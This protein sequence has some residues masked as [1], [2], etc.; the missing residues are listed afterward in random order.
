MARSGEI[1]V[2]TRRPEAPRD[3]DFAL[4]IDFK[5]G[6]PNPYRIFQ[7]ADMMIR[8]LQ[9]LDTTLC[10]TIDNKIEPIMVLEEI[11]SGSLIIWLRN[12]LTVIDDEALKKLDWKPAVGRYLVRAKHAYIRW[13]NKAD[14]ARS[15]SDLGQEIFNIAKETDVLQFPTYSPPPVRELADA[16]KEIEAAKGALIAE[17][18]ISYIMPD[19][20][21][22]L[23]LI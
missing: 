19:E 7:A 13:S 8:A 17:D 12:I 22:L 4:R 6:E 21:V 3:A 9:H 15:I 11:E 14:P 23:N 18:K 20:E 2:T 10:S 16:A 5:R 1:H